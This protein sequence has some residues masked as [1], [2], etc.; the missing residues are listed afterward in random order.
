[1]SDEQ[2]SDDKTEEAT[3]HR[4]QKAREGDGRVWW[5]ENRILR[6]LRDVKGDPNLEERIA[7]LE[8]RLREHPEDESAKLRLLVH[9]RARGE[10]GKIRSLLEPGCV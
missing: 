4:L 5:I 1:M 9:Y 6:V 2:S 3:L 8:A 10:S 7:R